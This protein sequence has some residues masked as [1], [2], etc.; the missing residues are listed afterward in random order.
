[1]VSSVNVNPR[2]PM[3]TALLP[4]PALEAHWPTL[5]AAAVL[6]ASATTLWAIVRQWQR[7]DT[8]P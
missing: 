3:L 4:L 5:A 6:L 8:G 2:I 1:M 7:G